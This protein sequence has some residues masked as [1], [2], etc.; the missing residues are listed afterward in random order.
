M[1]FINEIKTSLKHQSFIFKIYSFLTTKNN[2]KTSEDDK[3]VENK[4]NKH[5]SIPLSFGDFYGFDDV[6]QFPFVA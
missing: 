5:N 3:K 6:Q 1:W 4:V 2:E